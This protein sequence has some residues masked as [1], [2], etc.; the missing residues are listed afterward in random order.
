VKGCLEPVELRNEMLNHS[1]DYTPY[2]GRVLEEWPR[3][4][5]LSGRVMYDRENGGVV[6]RKGYREVIR[7][8]E[9]LSRWSKE[10]VGV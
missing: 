10:R 8:G 6:G 5:I 2:E 4:T 1:R 9:E 3:W 7:T